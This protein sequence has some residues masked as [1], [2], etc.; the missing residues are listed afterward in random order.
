MALLDVHDLKV[1]F[2]TPEGE[3][4]AVN[5]VS[6]QVEP[7]ETLA[8]VGE[9][10]SG[11]SQ[12]VMT[13]MGLLA[14]NG[15]A[16]GVAE[17]QGRDLMR[18]SESERNHVRGKD[19]AMIFQDPM[20]SLNPYLTIERQMTEVV[21]HHQKLSL[22]EA[23]AH[24]VEMLSAVRIPDAEERIRQYPHEFSGG[25]RQRV[26][27]AMGLLCEPDLLIADEPSTAL[28]VTVQAQITRL[29]AEL[30]EKTRMAIILITHDLAVVADVCDRILVMYAGQVVESGN[31]DDIFY[32]P[33]HPYTRGLLESVPR[34]DRPA[35]EALHAIPGNP[36]NLQ[37]LPS[38]CAFRDR[39][40]DAEAACR[41]PPPVWVTAN[42]RMSR[43]IQGIEGGEIV[44]NAAA[45]TSAADESAGAAEAIGAVKEEGG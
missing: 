38:G 14:E 29:F 42:G 13:I 22:H 23:R 5:G 44:D 39:C 2:D 9:S 28:D 7:G 27:I 19:I 3:V 11:K 37:A 18:M 1:R 31:V 6:F 25:M 45:A 10:G 20:T 12:L 15:T 4:Q 24:A 43:C 17:Y 30:R 35:D 26:M 21:M 41:E 36:P 40:P 34:L 33:Q 16:S 8:I 32:R